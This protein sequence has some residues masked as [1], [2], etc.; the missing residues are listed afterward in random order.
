M[1]IAAASVIRDSA[2][3]PPM[4]NRIR[5]TREFLR[6]LSLNAEKNWHQNRGAKR[7]VINSDEAMIFP[8]WARP[9]GR[10]RLPLQTIIWAKGQSSR[11]NR[12]MNCVTGGGTW[13]QRSEPPHKG[14]RPRKGPPV[15]PLRHCTQ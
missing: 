2:F 1:K 13:R 3:A 4:W 7:R 12:P 5:K 14:G 6:K 11:Q 15:T 8:N 10:G 9:G